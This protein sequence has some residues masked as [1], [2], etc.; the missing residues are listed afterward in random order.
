MIAAS[1]SRSTD[2]AAAFVVQVCEGIWM[3]RGIR[4]NAGT[5]VARMQRGKIWDAGIPPGRNLFVW[6]PVDR[7]R[8]RNLAD[9]KN[10]VASA[11]E[12]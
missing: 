5:A 11:T 4:G 6:E 3:A 8:C 1:L 10:L 2:I 12:Y 7:A 9:D